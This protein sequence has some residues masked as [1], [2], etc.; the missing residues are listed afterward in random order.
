MDLFSKYYS[1]SARPLLQTLRLSEKIIDEK[2]QVAVRSR[3]RSD[4][5]DPPFCLPPNFEKNIGRKIIMI[6]HEIYTTKIIMNKDL[7]TL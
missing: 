7:V 3:S 5:L 6:C 4:P 1:K 2:Y